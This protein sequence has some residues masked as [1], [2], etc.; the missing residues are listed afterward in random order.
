M[1]PY[2]E[3]INAIAPTLIAAVETGRTGGDYAAEFVSKVPDGEAIRGQMREAGAETVYA[4]VQMLPDIWN[5][6]TALPRWPLFL[7]EFLEWEPA[8]RPRVIVRRKE[9]APPTL[10]PTPAA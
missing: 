7:E 5:R 4:L 1:R 2:L 9:A 10:E 3:L 8:P 6:L